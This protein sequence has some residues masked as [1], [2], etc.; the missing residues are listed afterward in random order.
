[1]D[2]KIDPEF[3]DKI[4]PLTDAEFEQLRENILADGEVYEPICI[5]NGTIV[6]GHNRYK[7]VQE[8]PEI[9]YRT[10]EMQFA[11]KWEAFEWMYKK[12]LG[13][14]NLTDEQRTVLIGKMY[15]ARKKTHGGDRDTSHDENG[16]FTASTQNGNM[17][18]S[19]PQ[20]IS[21]QIAQELG[22]AKNT[23]IRA[24]RFSKGVD[25]IK[26]V[27]PEAAETILKGNSGVTKA[28]VMELPKKTDEEKKSFAEA[29]L[30]GSDE[31]KKARHK[32]K[33]S[34][35]ATPVSSQS[36]DEETMQPKNAGFSKEM[37]DSYSDTDKAYSALTD[38]GRTVE[39][40]VGDLADEIQANSDDFT[41]YLKRTIK[42]KSFLL[43][44]DNQK[45]IITEVLDYVIEAI[46][47]VREEIEAS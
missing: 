20:R 43:K 13:R 2:L 37:R 39:L 19:K 44:S 21:D 14:R 42:N 5:W 40:T 46:E 6:D 18:D 12:Q 34:G 25:A 32:Q 30:S 29:V 45:K 33:Q 28:A 17:R 47:K 41:N 7:I 31:V 27:S 38:Q 35:Q 22:I 10:K 11:D 16:K 24:E 8:H 9:P 36:N 4:P 15:E 3:R 26:E 23:V 1:M